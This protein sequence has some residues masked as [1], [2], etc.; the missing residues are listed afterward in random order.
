MKQQKNA[1][2]LAAR[3]AAG[4]AAPLQAIAAIPLE[5]SAHSLPSKDTKQNKVP[6]YLRLR[7]DL[8]SQID[9]LVIR[10][11]KE[12]GRGVSIQQ[13]IIELIEAELERQL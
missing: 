11:T 9:S 1:S 2:D 7:P 10:R 8:H 3:L 5:N 6:V 4:A 12:T 13:I